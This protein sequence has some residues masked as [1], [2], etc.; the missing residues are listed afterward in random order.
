[1]T[2]EDRYRGGMTTLTRYGSDHYR[3]ISKGRPRRAR[4]QEHRAATP[5]RDASSITREGVTAIK[6]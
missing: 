3:R 5:E 1:M 6:R 2:P 4:Y